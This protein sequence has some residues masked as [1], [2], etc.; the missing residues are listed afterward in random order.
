MKPL[1]SLGALLLAGGLPVVTAAQASAPQAQPL[2]PPR[3]TVPPEPAPRITPPLVKPK[4]PTV[5]PPPLQGG[6]P[7]PLGGYNDAARRCEAIG[8]V[9]QRAQCRD[10]VAREVPARPPS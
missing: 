10:R 9:Q 3:V 6:K 7:A 2:S 4:S 5:D 1:L 8:D